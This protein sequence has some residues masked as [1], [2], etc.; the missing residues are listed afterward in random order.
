MNSRFNPQSFVVL[1]KNAGLDPGGPAEL[2][3]VKWVDKE[4]EGG[5]LF[6][7]RREVDRG[8]LGFVGGDLFVED[9]LAVDLH[10]ETCALAFGV[11]QEGGITQ[12][13]QFFRGHGDA[14]GGAAEAVRIGMLL[15]GGGHPAGVAEDAFELQGEGVIHFRRAAVGHEI[16]DHAGGHASGRSGGVV[17]LGGDD[18]RPIFAPDDGQG[19]S[20]GGDFFGRAGFLKDIPDEALSAE[21]VRDF[22]VVLAE[23]EE[24]AAFLQMIDVAVVDERLDLGQRLHALPRVGLRGL[25]VGTFRAVKA[26]LGERD[27]ARLAGV[28]EGGED[29]E[30]MK[31]DARGV[32]AQRGG[33]VVPEARPV[34][35]RTPGIS[36]EASSLPPRS[37]QWCSSEM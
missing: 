5:F 37:V 17:E 20:K 26:L 9:G 19:E 28:E 16:V 10:G 36:R 34:R 24:E 18:V 15:E 27:A 7:P 33:F 13:A 1:S 3:A 31:G 30:V 14:P 21:R 11:I 23:A 6:G 22:G 8:A 32:E 4:V 25:A 29:F 35:R 2:I 12:H